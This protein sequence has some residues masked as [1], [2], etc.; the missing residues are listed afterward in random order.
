MR[1]KTKKK[2]KQKKHKK[3][4]E[5]KKKGFESQV[6]RFDF[7]VAALERVPTGDIQSCYQIKFQGYLEMSVVHLLPFPADNQELAE[8]ADPLQGPAKRKYHCSGIL[9]LPRGTNHHI[10]SG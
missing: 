4:A 5:V 9:S 6:H 1:Q 8:S 7:L 2:K 10:R 3:H